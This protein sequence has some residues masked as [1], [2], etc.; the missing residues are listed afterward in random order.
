MIEKTCP[1]KIKA[2]LSTRHC[3]KMNHCEVF[4]HIKNMS[5]F[6]LI[7]TNH[8]SCARESPK[9]WNKETI[10]L[11]RWPFYYKQLSGQLSTEE[12][13]ASVI[14]ALTL[15]SLRIQG[16]YFW[17]S[18]IPFSADLSTTNIQ[19][20][21]GDSFV[22]SLREKPPPSFPHGSSREQTQQH[23]T[24]FNSPRSLILWWWNW[25]GVGG[26]EHTSPEGDSG[27]IWDPNQNSDR[28]CLFDAWTTRKC[29]DWNPVGR[30]LF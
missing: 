5:N 12:F 24:F 15:S 26:R 21:S 17:L 20:K 9:R 10:E 22:H 28:I 19:V 23:V 6:F 25:L 14:F 27:F 18:E 13:G 29:K 7:F 30:D 11:K 2:C 16:C 1:K 4:C 8:K 3:L